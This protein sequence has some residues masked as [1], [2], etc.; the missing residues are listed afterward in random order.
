VGAFL[1]GN[2]EK[3]KREIKKSGI[4]KTRARDIYI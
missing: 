4:R 2:T 3:K 1:S